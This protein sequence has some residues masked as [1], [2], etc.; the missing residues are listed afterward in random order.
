MALLT[1]AREKAGQCS[2]LLGYLYTVLKCQEGLRYSQKAADIPAA[3]DPRDRCHRVVSS[4]T[5]HEHGDGAEEVGHDNELL[6]AV[7]VADHAPCE[8]CCQL[9]Q[10]IEGGLHKPH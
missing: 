7:S 1:D 8:G 3:N 10:R 5:K 6:A 4:Q 2:H 9:R